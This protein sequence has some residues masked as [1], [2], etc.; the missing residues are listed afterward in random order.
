MNNALRRNALL[1]S[2]QRNRTLQKTRRTPGNQQY[3]RY[4]TILDVNKPETKAIDF[5][6]SRGTPYF[7]EIGAVS[8]NTAIPVHSQSKFMPLSF[9][10]YEG[11]LP[12]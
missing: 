12:L 8:D 1:H 4:T 5:C 7:H 6:D 3:T 11:P 2:K 10:R 9:G